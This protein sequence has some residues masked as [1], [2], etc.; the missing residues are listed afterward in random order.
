VAF[1]ICEVSLFPIKIN[2][3]KAIKQQHPLRCTSVAVLGA[4]SEQPQR[5][6]STT[7]RAS[8]IAFATNHSYGI[9]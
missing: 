5:V 1:E 8:M 2:N 3:P 7:N 4:K 9:F 6:V